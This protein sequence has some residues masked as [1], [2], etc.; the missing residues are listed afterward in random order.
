MVPAYNFHGPSQHVLYSTVYI[1]LL[2]LFLS[3]QVS[4]AAEDT[5]SLLAPALPPEPTVDLLCPMV[6]REKYPMLLG[7]IRLLTKVQFKPLNEGDPWG[8]YKSPLLEVSYIWRFKVRI[9]S[10]LMY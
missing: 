9:Y 2:L 4:Q 5:F 10:T 6:G 7:C 8:H 1:N 3:R